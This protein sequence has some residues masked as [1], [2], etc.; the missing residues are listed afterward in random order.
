MVT[1]MATRK[2]AG[3][4][5]RRT[6]RAAGPVA[7]RLWHIDMDGYDRRPDDGPAILCPNH[8]SFLDSAFLMLTMPR[9]ISFVGKAEYMDSWKTK[10]IFPA[11]GMI[12]IDR[13]GGNATER[14][15]NT[16]AGGVQRSGLFGIYPAGTRSPGGGLHRGPTRPPRPGVRPAAPT[17]PL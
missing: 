10:Y 9:N 17:I 11:M 12:P 2:G 15:L 8:V 7:R 3:T 1:V 4:A 13:S 14:A 16:A 6:R 5:Q